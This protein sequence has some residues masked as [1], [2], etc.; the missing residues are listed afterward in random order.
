[1]KGFILS[2]SLVLA[3]VLFAEPTKGYSQGCTVSSSSTTAG[4][5]TTSCFVKKGNA[6]TY[7]LTGT[8]VGQ[9]DLQLSQDGGSSWRT[10]GS[11]TANSA[12]VTSKADTLTDS[13]IRF[14]VAAWTSGSIVYTLTDVTATQGRIRYPTVDIGQTA[15][16]SL[17]ISIVASTTSAGVSDLFVAAEMNSTGGGILVGATGGTDKF[18]YGLYNSAG[19]LV[20][21]TDLAGVTASATTNAFQEIPWT[22]P[23]VLPA[24]RYLLL[25]QVNG[26]TATFRRPA[27][28]TFINVATESVTS[29]TFGTL[30]ANITVPTAMATSVAVGGTNG[31]GPIGYVY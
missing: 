22:V 30:P 1:M 15:Y 28:N 7:G 10:I 12:G 11:F 24:G 2:I 18:I 23:T 25:V 14:Y 29:L 3:I 26:T 27:I 20:A 5:A 6:I 21:N 16:S 17:G 4:T 9:M 19:Q 31:I 13:R 8:W